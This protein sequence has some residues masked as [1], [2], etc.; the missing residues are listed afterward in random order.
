MKLLL[1]ILI[2]INFNIKT[3]SQS[4]VSTSGS[5]S[6]ILVGSDSDFA[7]INY[8]N[9]SERFSFNYKFTRQDN[10]RKEGRDFPNFWG[11]N[12]GS[13]VKIQKGKTNIVANEIWQGGVDFDLT[14]FRAWNKN[15][16]LKIINTDEA[17]V[18]GM[19]I[20]EG[21]AEIH[22]STLFLRL[23]DGIERFYSFERN[24][25]N[26][27][28]TFLM[29]DNPLQ[30]N[31]TVTPGFYRLSQWKSNV[32]FSYGLSANLSFINNSTQNLS[33]FTITPFQGNFLNAK[34]STEFQV[35]GK[36]NTYYE[37]KS[38]SELF[39]VP[40]VD[41]FP[42]FQFG[43]DNPYFGLLFSYSPLISSIESVKTRNAF[44]FGPTF[45]LNTFPDH[46]VFAIMNELIQDKMLNY[47]YTLTFHASI[48]IKF[49]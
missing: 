15:K 14:I 48:P 43:K 20:T 12:I 47:N 49:K 29:I 3:L 25:L 5:K 21:S 33:V 2:L 35:T 23:S 38:Q 36:E 13:S 42:R 27:D 4:I 17:E 44:A 8:E 1:L 45:G 31:L 39:F 22:Q 11:I 16:N 40:R 7:G 32:L 18:A 34:D 26:S 37:G 19:K 28:T 30:N 24:V 41:L 9:S 46:V 6:G 10:E